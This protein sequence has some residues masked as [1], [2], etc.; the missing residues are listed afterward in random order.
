MA[1]VASKIEME[2]NGVGAGWT[3]ID[4]VVRA[5][6]ISAKYGIQGNTPRDRVASPGPMTFALDNSTNNSGRKL[7]YYSPGHA[8]CRI[9]FGVGIGVRLV[10]TIPGD[11]PYY[12]WRG[13]VKKIRPL[14]GRYAERRTV[15]VCLDWMDEAATTL[16]RSLPIQLNKRSDQIFTTLID[17]TG[18]EGEWEGIRRQPGAT[19][20][21]EGLHSFPYVFDSLR[22]ETAFVLREFQRVALSELGV[23][24][25]KGDAVQGETLVYENGQERGKKTVNAVVLDSTREIVAHESQENVLNDVTATVHP[26]RVDENAV[27]LFNLEE[28]PEIQSWQSIN[29]DALY[30]DPELLATRTAGF[31][32]IQPVPTTD[33]TFNTEQDGT[34]QDRTAQLT[35]KVVPGGNSARVVISNNIYIGGGG[36]GYRRGFIPSGYL[37]KFH[38]RGKGLYAYD[39]VLSRMQDLPSQYEHGQ[40]S[41]SLDMPY[42]S[43]PAMAQRAASFIVHQNAA[44][45]TRVDSIRFIAN[46]SDA[47]M[48]QAVAREVGDRVGITEEVTGVTSELVDVIMPLLSPIGDTFMGP[49]PGQSLFGTHPLA[50]PNGRY[51]YLPCGAGAAA[52]SHLAVIDIDDPENPVYSELIDAAFGNIQ[53]CA[54]EGD[55]LYICDGDNSKIHII[56][57]STPGSPVYDSAFTHVNVDDPDQIA[58][59]RGWLF[60]SDDGGA[61]KGVHVLDIS[62]PD[63]PVLDNTWIGTDWPRWLR[64]SRGGN[65]LAVLR[66]EVPYTLFLLDVSDPT[67]PSTLATITADYPGQLDRLLCVEFSAGDGWLYVITTNGDTSQSTISVLDI[68]VP[69]SPVWVNQNAA[70]LIEFDDEDDAVS[71]ND[72]MLQPEDKTLYAMGTSIDEPAVGLSTRGAAFKVVNHTNVF[73][74][75]DY[76]C[77]GLEKLGNQ[78]YALVRV[79]PYPSTYGVGMVSNGSGVLG[80]QVFKLRHTFRQSVSHFINSIELTIDAEGVMTCSWQLA[81]S[82]AEQVWVLGVAGFTELGI[83]TRLAWGEVI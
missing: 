46:R 75:V 66:P 37:T 63:A 54:I 2:L 76:P 52:P 57:I 35:I 49:T 82:L 45:Y 70:S 55:W 64:L 58:S 43:V 3:A 67:S 81:P 33:Y 62:T 14:S 9:G 77:S 65:I 31:D 61:V 19:L 20:V 39:A 29:F 69:A 34:G 48:A 15:V 68:R 10:L 50:H 44:P 47:L 23:I 22:D 41:F 12:K 11:P 24:Y 59:K 1:S 28:K 71:I 40:N 26:R 32:I 6:P 17:G 13:T 21:S 51:V 25:I 60:V 30:R 27:V 74:F 83:T 8:D 5:V 79:P 80:A 18:V 7:G 42:Q 53:E 38:L 16:I 56:D 73:R 36:G 78:A 4:D 72:L